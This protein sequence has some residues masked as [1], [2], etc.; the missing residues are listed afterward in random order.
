MKNER[1]KKKTH[2]NI[3]INQFPLSSAGT[4]SLVS[5]ISCP[6]TINSIEN[7]EKKHFK[8][9]QSLSY[10]HSR[11]D[12]NYQRKNKREKT[13]TCLNTSVNVFH[14]D[15]H[16]KRNL[17]TLLRRL[18]TITELQWFWMFYMLPPE[19]INKQQKDPQVKDNHTIM[20]QKLAISIFSVES[21]D[22]M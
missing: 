22:L 4:T 11:K 7:K 1:R 9:N 19:R 5:P 10:L 2:F 3:Q 18:N 12:M 14:T 8:Q 15:S 6:V 17:G 21:V 16:R 20:H 13:D